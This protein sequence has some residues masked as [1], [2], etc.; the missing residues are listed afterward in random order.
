[1][2]SC[3]A[4]ATTSASARWLPTSMPSEKTTSERGSATSLPFSPLAP[5]AW[6]LAPSKLLMVWARKS[7]SGVA[8]SLALGA[9]PRS[10][11]TNSA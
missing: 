3:T 7:K 9:L 5:C 11:L 2:R 6:A 10:S 1:M 8:K 4:S